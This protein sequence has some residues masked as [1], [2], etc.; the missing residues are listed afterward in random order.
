MPKKKT[1][2]FQDCDF[3]RVATL[4]VGSDRLCMD[5]EGRI[6]EDPE[7]LAAFKGLV[8]AMLEATK[9]NFRFGKIC[10]TE[11]AYIVD[12][13]CVAGLTNQDAEIVALFEKFDQDVERLELNAGC[14]DPISASACGVSSPSLDVLEAALEM[15]RSDNVVSVVLD[16]GQ[17]IELTAPSQDA[18]TALPPREKK[19]RKVDGEITGMGW[20]D[21]RGSRLEVGNGSMF[22]VSR[23][24]L[25]EAYELVSQKQHI[26]GVATWDHDAYVLDKPVYEKELGI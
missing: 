11:G 18:I 24:T 20:G 7:L 17:E 5:E 12:V 9:A 22:L 25:E 2:E 23:L 14:E 26:S 10:V 3:V 16:D 15:R 6:I 13:C 4:K 21:E 1:V 19:S 8:D